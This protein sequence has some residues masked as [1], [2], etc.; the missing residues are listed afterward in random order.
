MPVLWT[1]TVPPPLKREQGIGETTCPIVCPP[2]STRF[3]NIVNKMQTLSHPPFPSSY[4]ILFSLVQYQIQIP[5][6]LVQ[7]A[8]QVTQSQ[9]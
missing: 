5:T 7:A 1:V 3:S 8:N 6:L 4:K 9:M 2:R